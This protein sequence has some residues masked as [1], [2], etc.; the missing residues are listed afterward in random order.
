MKAKT[1]ETKAAMLEPVGL[2]EAD[3]E[4]LKT[5]RDRRLKKDSGESEIER[6]QRSDEVIALLKEADGTE[7][8]RL[9]LYGPANHFAE[10]LESFLPL[11]IAVGPN[12]VIQ[13]TQMRLDLLQTMRMQNCRLI[14]EKVEKLGIATVRN[15]TV[16]FVKTLRDEVDSFRYGVSQIPDKVAN[17]EAELREYLKR[18][19]NLSPGAKYAGIEAQ[20]GHPPHDGD[21]GVE[22]IGNL[23]TGHGVER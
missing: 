6:M 9:V 12:F 16:P 5:D 19:K 1:G 22:V 13:I 17:L 10:Q 23:S 2:S 20:E 4:F 15:R 14:H 3:K 21:D 11:D 18:K 8:R 7:A